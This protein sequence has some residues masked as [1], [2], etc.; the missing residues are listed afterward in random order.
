VQVVVSGALGIVLLF[1]WIEAARLSQ[2]QTKIFCQQCKFE[3]AGQTQTATRT[4]R[5][6]EKDKSSKRMCF[7]SRKEQHLELIIRT[8]NRR[9]PAIQQLVKIRSPVF[10]GVRRCSPAGASFAIR[11]KSFKSFSIG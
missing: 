6:A 8:P 7:L 10:V 2:W 1:W 5:I 9:I 4:G 11:N 3:S